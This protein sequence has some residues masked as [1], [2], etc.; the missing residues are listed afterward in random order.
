MKSGQIKK[1][2]SLLLKN[3]FLL[4]LSL[5]LSS[6]VCEVG[7]RIVSPAPLLIQGDR[8]SLPIGKKQQFNISGSKKLDQT[9]MHWRNKIGFRG[10]EPPPDFEKSL[11]IVA[12]GGSTTECSL[13]SEGDTWVDRLGN[14]LQTV[15]P[16]IWINNA[17]LDGHSTFGHRLLLEQHVFPMKPKVVLLMIGLNDRGKF[18]AGDIEKRALRKGWLNNLLEES[19][20]VGMFRLVERSLKAKQVHLSHE[21]IDFKALVPKTLSEDERQRIL[22]TYRGQALDD[23]SLR[24]KDLIAMTRN[25]GSLPVLITQSAVYG[26]GTDDVTG[27][28]LETVPA[29]PGNGMTAWDVLELYNNVLRARAKDEGVPLVDLAA[30]MPKSTRYYYDYIH[31]TKEGADKV[32]AILFE[33]LCPVLRNSFPAFAA[34]ACG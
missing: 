1:G 33:T 5:V 10:A 30:A 17:G 4:A 31:Y 22:N 32:S 34:N 11:S 24:V 14:R 19:R 23:F 12:V 18:D 29:S 25:N 2:A 27:I 8:I 15:F 9:V 28:N 16:D 21:D 26:P 20:L 6:L 13:L 3:I 7:L